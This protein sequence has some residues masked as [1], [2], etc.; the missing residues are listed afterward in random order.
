MIEARPD[1]TRRLQPGLPVSV[2]LL[3]AG[4]VQAQR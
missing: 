2:K 3:N 4:T 1:P